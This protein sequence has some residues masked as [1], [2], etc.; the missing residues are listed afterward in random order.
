MVNNKGKECFLHDRKWTM[1]DANVTCKDL[2]YIGAVKKL[3][4]PV[5]DESKTI[6][7]QEYKC[8]GT[9]KYMIECRSSDPIN[10]NSSHKK[11]AAV[12]CKHES[13]NF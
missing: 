4:L 3:F 8:N 1:A 5:E 10:L 2:G 11:V 7:S 12:H 13:K 6:I 9:E